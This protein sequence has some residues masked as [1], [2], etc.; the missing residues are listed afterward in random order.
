VRHD[1]AGTADAVRADLR[2]G[3]RW[4]RSVVFE[5]GPAGRSVVIDGD[6]KDGPSP[7]ETLLFAL[8]TCTAV[9]VVLMLDKRRTPAATFEM[10]VSAERADDTP[11]RLTKAH[12]HYRITGAGIER[13]HALRSIRLA[14]TKYCTVRD[15]LDPDMPVTWSLELS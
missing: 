10:D 8:A 15:T 5:A 7:P 1:C 4:V 3:V 14:V 6:S 11:R 12:L 13:S 9:D 2:I